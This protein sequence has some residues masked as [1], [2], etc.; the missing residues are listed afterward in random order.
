LLGLLFGAAVGS[1]AG[2]TNP[3]VQE[4]FSADQPVRGLLFEGMRLTSGATVDA[5]FG[6]RPLFEADMLARGKGS[7]ILEHPPN[8]VVWL[9][10]VRALEGRAMKPGELISR[11]P[12]RPCRRR[13]RA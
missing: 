3:A 11:A 10:Q 5:A 13:S 1:K 6:V 9:A 12:S 2:L 4:R 7:D 8:A